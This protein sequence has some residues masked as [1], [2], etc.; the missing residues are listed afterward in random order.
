M[1]LGVTVGK[2]YPFHRGHEHLITEAASQCDRLVVLLCY[3]PNQELPGKVRAAWIRECCPT[4]EVLEVIDDLPNE[5][6]PWAQ[7]TIDLL[8]RE[9]DV[10]F[11]SEEYGQEYAAR[12]GCRHVGIDLDRR[13]FP[14]S[15]TALREDL[16]GHWDYLTGPAKAWLA[17]R[18]C[19][20]GVESS[21][22][23]TLAES[24]ARRY[25]TVWV[26]EYGRWYWE[27][28]R[29]SPNADEWTSDEFLRIARGQI[30]WEEDL[31]RRANQ[32]VV[33]DTD[34]LATYV[35]HRRYVGGHYPPL[36][37]L[38]TSREYDLYLL[39]EPD[40]PYVQDGTRESEAMRS[41]M[42]RW[43]V[44]ALET[45]GRRYL[46]VGGTPDERLE[47]AVE[48]IE[49]LLDFPRLGEP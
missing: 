16:A 24:L 33:A 47:A 28:R 6:E 48:A 46:R 29:Y 31:A 5:S 30:A 38:A 21:G 37:S 23:T 12:M 15:G 7:R 42:H 3:K 14:V 32:L 9:P 4:V 34:P 17:R 20:V 18:V 45:S 8:G 44:E 13:A 35:W 36:W 26:P 41:Q 10:A 1:S 49:P 2:F 39:T 43:F 22:T 25:Q 27:G 19:V 11:T 40:F